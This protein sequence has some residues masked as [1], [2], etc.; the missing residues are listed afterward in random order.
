MRF[1]LSISGGGV[2]GAM[3]AKL[4]DLLRDN[5]KSVLDR[6][7]LTIATSQ[8]SLLAF[9]ASVHPESALVDLFSHKNMSKMLHKSVWDHV[10]QEAQFEP[11]YDGRGKRSIIQSYVQHRRLSS[12]RHKII[13]PVYNVSK[14]RPELVRTWQ[15]EFTLAEVADAASAAVPYFPAVQMSNSQ[16]YIDGG[17]VANNPLLIAYAEARALY[18]RDPLRILSIGTGI[19]APS[20]ALGAEVKNWGAIQWLSNGLV[21]LGLDGSNEIMVQ[22]ASRLIHL[23]STHNRL[24]HIDIPIHQT[25]F[26]DVDKIPYLV[27]KGEEMYGMY[28]S[29]LCEFF[30]P[31]SSRSWHC[32]S[33]LERPSL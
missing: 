29:D 15:D 6:F 26:D 21:E 33:R 7:D 2:R 14:R 1:I 8:G 9:Y 22:E 12:L 30:T 18:P 3:A 32:G 23:D 25:K 5:E 31:T 17:Y 20:G 16:L 28:K 4:L 24:L 13:V 19:Q 11:V 27:E 10:M